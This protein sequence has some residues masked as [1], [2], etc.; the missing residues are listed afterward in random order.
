[1]RAS[2]SSVTRQAPA[3]FFT[4][5]TSGSDTDSKAK[6]RRGSVT[7]TLTAD[8]VV[9]SA[10]ALGTQRLLHRM[11]DEGHLPRISQRRP[12]ADGIYA[13]GSKLV[14]A[15]GGF[16]LLFLAFILAGAVARQMSRSMR[17]LR[18]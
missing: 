18:P 17:Q 15:R 9:F 8:Q 4:A 16:L 5:L 7:R 3:A 12:L 2:T 10:S 6:L 14:W 11:R 13:D 1:M